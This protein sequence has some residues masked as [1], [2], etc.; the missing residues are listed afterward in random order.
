MLSLGAPPKPDDTFTWNYNEKDGKF[1]SV[2]STPLEFYKD[3]IGA[4]SYI[5]TPKLGL[6]EKA[7]GIGNRFSL[8]NDPRNPYMRLLS[9]E[10][11]GNVHGGRGIQYV[12]VSMEVSY[13]IIRFLV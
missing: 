12:N 5:G 13:K 8:V 4:V 2:T 1:H 3:N 9:V 11:L 7:N 10:R 6:P